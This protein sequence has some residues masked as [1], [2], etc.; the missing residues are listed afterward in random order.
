MTS[1]TSKDKRKLLFGAKRL[2]SDKSLIVPKSI[3]DVPTKKY[4]ERELRLTGNRTIFLTDSG[5]EYFRTVVDVMD[6]ADSF[7]GKADYSDIWRAWRKAVEKWLSDG[8]EP[9]SAD[10]IAQAIAGLVA[11]EID[12]RTFVVP[13]FG[14]ELHGVDS[15]TLGAMTILPMSVDVFDSAGVKHDHADVP[16][17]TSPRFS[18]AFGFRVRGLM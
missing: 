17:P 7:E 13:L 18:V 11:Q 4:F 8:L 16:R 9:E 14:I 1:L 10:E 6:R 12:D 2:F 3:G 5:Y 15:F